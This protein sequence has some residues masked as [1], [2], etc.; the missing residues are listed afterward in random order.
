MVRAKYFLDYMNKKAASNESDVDVEKGRREN[1]MYQKKWNGGS[2]EKLINLCV[3]GMFSV[4]NIQNE[5]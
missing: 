3:Y 2:V 5:I 1:K 4:T